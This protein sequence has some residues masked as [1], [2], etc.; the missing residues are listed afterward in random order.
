MKGT[1]YLALYMDDN[2]MIGDIAAINDAIEVLKNKGL[3]LK[4][5]EGLQDYLSCKVKFSDNKKHSWYDSPFYSR[6]WKRNLV[7]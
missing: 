5:M 6:I 7:G 3:V 1:A 4:I 2:L